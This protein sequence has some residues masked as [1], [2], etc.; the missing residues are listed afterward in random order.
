MDR[1][2]FI[3]YASG[4]LALAG[5]A[6]LGGCTQKEEPQRLGNQTSNWEMVM[7]KKEIDEPLI[8]PYAENSPAA[9]RDAS[10]GRM[11]PG[12]QPQTAGG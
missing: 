9:Y 12:F 3:K 7:G 1:R 10:L 4:I 5:V 2:Y 11:T 8:P 6:I